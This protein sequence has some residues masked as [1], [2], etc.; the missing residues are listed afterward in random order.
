MRNLA[1]L[2]CSV[3]TLILEVVFVALAGACIVGVSRHIPLMEWFPLA[4]TVLILVGD[5]LTSGSRARKTAAPISEPVQRAVAPSSHM[6]ASPAKASAP[7]SGALAV[8][9]QA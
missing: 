6:G 8:G 4:A 5:P 9:S 1:Q 2:Y 3:R 7:A